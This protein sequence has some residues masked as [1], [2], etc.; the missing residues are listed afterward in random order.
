MPGRTKFFTWKT[1]KKLNTSIKHRAR[2][3]R[4][5]LLKNLWCAHIFWWNVY[6]MYMYTKRLCPTK[7]N[8]LTRIFL[9]IPSFFIFSFSLLFSYPFS[10]SF[11]RSVSSIKKVQQ[12]ENLVKLNGISKWRQKWLSA[13]RIPYLLAFFTIRRYRYK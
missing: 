2:K 9:L 12:L 10:D 6:C 1:T 4:S 7:R 8:R 11:Y 13:P 3:N 5:H